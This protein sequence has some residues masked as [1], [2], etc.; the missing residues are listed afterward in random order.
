MQLGNQPVKE[1]ISIRSQTTHWSNYQRSIEQHR[2][3][4]NYT[5]NRET[6]CPRVVILTERI[7]KL[8]M[9]AH[10]NDLEL[11]TTEKVP[12]AQAQVV[13]E[14]IFIK[15]YQTIKRKLARILVHPESRKTTC[16]LENQREFRIQ[17]NLI[18]P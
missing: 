7:P 16:I 18:A 17:P 1:S 9:H 5:M 4:F 3:R 2:I 10:K 6:K 8:L 15:A 13:G 14:G 11:Y 12:I